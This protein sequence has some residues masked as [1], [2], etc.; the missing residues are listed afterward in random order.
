[1]NNFFKRASIDKNISA[2]LL[3][4]QKDP[5]QLEFEFPDQNRE[6]KNQ[7]DSKEVTFKKVSQAFSKAVRFIIAVF[8][9]LRP[10]DFAE[11][12]SLQED[13]LFLSDLIREM[14]MENQESENNSELNFFTNKGDKDE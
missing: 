3:G 9:N 8:I 7:S 1:M 12:E 2:S 10:A 11:N 6:L 5:R 14:I 13:L 4:K